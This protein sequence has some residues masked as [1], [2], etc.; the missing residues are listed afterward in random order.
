MGFQMDDL[1]AILPTLQKTQGS[2]FIGQIGQI[3]DAS[4]NSDDLQAGIVNLFNE[5]NLSYRKTLADANI[6]R[7][8]ETDT[9]ADRKTLNYPLNNEIIEVAA[10]IDAKAEEFNQKFLEASAEE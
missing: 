9:E 6:L 1:K 10:K 2:D 3:V 5:N 7:A 8:G 4:M